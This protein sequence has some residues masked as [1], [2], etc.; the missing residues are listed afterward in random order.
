MILNLR[1]LYTRTEYYC[2]FRTCRCK[3]VTL[4]T[5]HAVK[6]A[7]YFHLFPL[8]GSS[9]SHSTKL[10]SLPR[11]P[12]SP[13]PLFSSPCFH[14]FSHS[15]PCHLRVSSLSWMP[16]HSMALFV[17]SLPGCLRAA[18]FWTLVYSY[19][20][21]CACTA[22]VKLFCSILMGPKR[23][24]KKTPREVTPSCLND[25]FLGTHCYVRIKVMPLSWTNQLL[26]ILS[27]LPAAFN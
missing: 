20:L 16:G 21:L 24:F 14:D 9:I 4:E 7:S 22:F 19:C 1:F 25:P 6:A 23:T 12:S 5:E 15:S 3:G 18:A 13:P 27:L 17:D 2:V 10:Q 26:P 11:S 8:R